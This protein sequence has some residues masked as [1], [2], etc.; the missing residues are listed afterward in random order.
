M[1]AGLT[2]I[3]WPVVRRFRDAKLGAYK[4]PTQEAQEG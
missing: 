1:P 2:P 4:P 3:L